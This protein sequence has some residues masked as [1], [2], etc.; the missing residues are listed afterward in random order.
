MSSIDVTNLTLDYIK[1]R[2]VKSLKQVLSTP[3]SRTPRHKIKEL[4]GRIFRAL[5]NIS[6]HLENGDRL[7]LI[8]R[9]GAGKSTLLRVLSGIY[10]PTFGSINIQG[11]VSTL[12][13]PEVGVNI[14]ATGYENINLMGIVHGHSKKAIR[15]LYKQ[16]EDFSEL[17]SHLHDPIRTYSSGMRARLVFATLT[18]L[19]HDIIL[20]DEGIGTGDKQFIEKAKNKLNEMLYSANIVILASHS[21]SIVKSICNK[22][23]VLDKGKIQFFGGIQE[24]LDYYNASITKDTATVG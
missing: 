23:L 5:D 13:A 12:L 9:N 3:L 18:A 16:I 15:S 4:N 7:G 11:R 20:L 19:S 2:K 1:G 8:G 24:G 10:K 21:D 17:G 6:F 14:E 22:A